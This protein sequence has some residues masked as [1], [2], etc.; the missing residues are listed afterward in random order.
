MASNV[1]RPLVNGQN[2]KSAEELFGWLS[3]LI[4]T[5]VSLQDGQ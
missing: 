4:D 2:V 3:A 5:P 1:F